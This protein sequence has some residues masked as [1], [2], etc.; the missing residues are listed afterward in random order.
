MRIPLW[1]R[2]LSYLWDFEIDARSSEINQELY[3][4]LCRG[5]LQLNT[6]KV[7][8]S[9]ELKYY[10][11]AKLFNHKLDLNRLNG[12]K[13]LVLGLGLGSIIQILDQIRPGYW[14]IVAVEIDEEVCALASEY[15]LSR[16]ESNLAIHMADAASFVKLSEQNFDLIC[17]DIFVDD[18]IPSSFQ[19]LSFLRDIQ[20]RL[21]D[22]GVVVYNTLA[23]RKS[24]KAKSNQFFEETFT[25][26]FPKGILVPSHRNY[27]LINSKDLM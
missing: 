9:H 26:V 22:G 10:N 11:F 14:D 1:K 13:V 19:E 6:D 16:V 18:T 23:S 7:V 27:M 8:Y 2:W 15:T 25:Q 4:V 24:D 12:N 21:N 20:N 3:V 17:I 5:Q